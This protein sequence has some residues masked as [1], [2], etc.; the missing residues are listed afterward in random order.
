MVRGALN[1]FNSTRATIDL[2]SECDPDPSLGEPAASAVFCFKKNV[3]RTP[4]TGLPSPDTSQGK[5]AAASVVNLYDDKLTRLEHVAAVTRDYSV[6]PLI[7]A[8]V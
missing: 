6:K 8:P 2:K 1:Q 3:V 7:G 5:M 4:R